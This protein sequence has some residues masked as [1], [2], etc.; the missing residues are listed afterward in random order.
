MTIIR[1]YKM[2]ECANEVEKVFICYGFITIEDRSRIMA[3]II[4][5]PK[6]EKV[7]VEDEDEKGA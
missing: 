7:I 5:A 6:K 1:Q 2:I 4:N 3:M